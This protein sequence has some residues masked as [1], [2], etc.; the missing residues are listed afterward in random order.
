M[1]RFVQLA[2][3]A[4]SLSLLLAA[5]LPAA[6][7]SPGPQGPIVSVSVSEALRVKAVETYGLPEVERLAEALRLDVE[8]ELRRT[9]VMAGGRV[10]LVLS[11]AKPNRPT[12]Q[13]L[14]ARPGLSFRSFSVGGA[15]IEG[16][17]I[18]FDGKTIPVSYSWY[19][20]DITDARRQ[21]VWG[22][23]EWAFE[24]FARRLSRGQLYALR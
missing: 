14:A 3:A 10:E 22:D 24:R 9:G 12:T 13:E 4:L 6:Q 1:P 19:A 23:A 18:S 20:S 5:A 2:L 21:A 15:A 11:D 8:R 16:E 7:A 17:M